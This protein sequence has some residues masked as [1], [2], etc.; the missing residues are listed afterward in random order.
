MPREHFDYDP[1]TGVQTDFD[2]DHATGKVELFHTQDIQHALEVANISRING[3]RDNGIKENW[4][5]Y[6]EIP[7][8][9][10]L[11]LRKMGISWDDPKEINRAVNTYW[12]ELKMTTKK[13]GGKIGNTF[14]PSRALT[15]MAEQPVPA[16][17]AAPAAP[18]I[19][20]P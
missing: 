12:P 19:A 18:A 8:V 2:Y 5:H 7:M 4:F 6:A 15:E 16:A 3:L 20:L 17:P 1:L 11:K 14:L 9:H 10:L 13:E